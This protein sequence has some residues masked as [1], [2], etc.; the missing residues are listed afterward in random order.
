LTKKKRVFTLPR[1]IG[2]A[3]QRGVEERQR[4]E[5]A[6]KQGREDEG[7]RWLMWYLASEE[8]PSTSYDWKLPAAVTA[9]ATATTAACSERRR[10]NGLPLPPRS[11]RQCAARDPNH[12]PSGDF[13]GRGVRG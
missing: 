7:V 5:K 6:G 3:R 13:L 2:E 9:T 11:R 8:D 12:L 4:G 1:L 10:S